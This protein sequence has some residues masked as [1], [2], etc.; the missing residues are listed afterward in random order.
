[1]GSGALAHIQQI[2]PA[3][4]KVVPA[5]E[6]SRWGRKIANGEFVTS[7]EVL[8]PK[9][10]DAQKTLDSIRLLKD[11]GVDGVNIPD[12]RPPRNRA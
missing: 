4:I 7:V 10:V 6:R 9:G 12:R 11:A 1:M 8:P 5:E 3:D 2:I